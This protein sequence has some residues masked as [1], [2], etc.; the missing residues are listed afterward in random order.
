VRSK[1]IYET[2]TSGTPDAPPFYSPFASLDRTRTALTYA[3]DT[4]SAT[5]Y[6]VKDSFNSVD[7]HTMIVE[8]LTGGLILDVDFTV[9]SMIN[10]FS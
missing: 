5:D 6:K 7:G 10:P 1:D 9:D 8:V 2:H 4:V 3:M